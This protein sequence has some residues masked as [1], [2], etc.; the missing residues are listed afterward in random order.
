MVGGRFFSKAFGSGAVVAA[1]ALTTEQ[2]GA[3]AVP[4]N[5]QLT[6]T[7]KSMDFS[8]FSLTPLDFT[9]GVQEGAPMTA[10]AAALDNSGPAGSILFAVRRPG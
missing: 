9:L 3:V 10:Q 6:P 2:V 1:V 4:E 8:S 7:M 5:L